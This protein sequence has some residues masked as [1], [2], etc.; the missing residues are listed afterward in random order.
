MQIRMLL[1][2][3]FATWTIRVLKTEDTSRET[4][5]KSSINLRR[6]FK[7]CIWEVWKQNWV[8]VAWFYF[9][10]IFFLIYGVFWLERFRIFFY[11]LMLIWSSLL[12]EK[13]ES[14]QNL[15]RTFLF[16]FFAKKRTFSNQVKANWHSFTTPLSQCPGETFSVS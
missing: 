11:Q 5:Y 7:R 12:K 13:K 2:T 4:N 10:T 16:I 9:M 14:A 6:K 8:S 1:Q 3:R 15:T